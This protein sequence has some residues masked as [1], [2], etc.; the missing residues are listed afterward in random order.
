MGAVIKMDITNVMGINLFPFTPE[1]LT[2]VMEKSASENTVLLQ[3]RSKMDLP[4]GV[5][6]HDSYEFVINLSQ[7]FTSRLE[8]RSLLIRKNHLAVINPGQDHGTHRP[9]KGINLLGLHMDSKFLQ[10]VSRE[11]YGTGAVYFNNSDQLP[12]SSFRG[13]V[14]LF[15]EESAL[16]QPGYRFI[17][18][19]LDIHLAVCLLR[20]PHISLPSLSYKFGEKDNIARAIEFIRASFNKDFSLKDVSGVANLSP[21]HFIRV[22]KAQTGKTPYEFLLDYKIEKARELLAAGN[23]TVTEVCYQ[24][25]FNNRSHF[26]AAFKKRVGVTPT[27]YRNTVSR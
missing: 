17:L 24:C 10:K 11:V 5:H 25:G 6:Q 1:Q 9:M 3:S 4:Q 21:Y 14:N 18:Q 2:L 12:D 20:L 13:L 7:T 27:G 26:T 19:S 8:K 23:L 22:F 15:M 16:R